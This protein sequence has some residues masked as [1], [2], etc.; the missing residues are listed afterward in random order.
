MRCLEQVGLAEL[1]TRRAETLSGGQQQRVAI[2][3]VLMQDTPV[4]LADEPVASLDPGAGREVME[5]LWRV[6]KGR[7]VICSLHQLDLALQYG[8]RIVALRDGQVAL[9]TPGAGLSLEALRALY[10]ARG[11]ARPGMP[12]PGVALPTAV[13]AAPGAIHDG[14]R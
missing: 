1:A 10:P 13:G 12:D 6:L 7:T 11:G 4:V 14:P 9:D 5:L 2:A 8:E 3:R